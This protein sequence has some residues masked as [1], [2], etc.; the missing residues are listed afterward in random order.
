MKSSSKRHSG[1][2]RYRFPFLNLDPDS[3]TDP[4]GYSF[5][6]AF[7][8]GVTGQESVGIRNQ[9]SLRDGAGIKVERR[10]LVRLQFDYPDILD[11]DIS[12]R[13]KF[14]ADPVGFFSAA[15]CIPRFEF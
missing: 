10:N 14:Q 6:I 11:L 15:G 4:D 7:C 8:T 1:R 12:L 9:E 5:C 3:D 13:L 2:Y